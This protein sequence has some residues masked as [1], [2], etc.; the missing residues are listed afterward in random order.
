MND[1]VNELLEVDVIVG[2]ENYVN[3]SKIVGGLFGV[4][5]NGLIVL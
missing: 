1:L 2:F 4:E 3:L 5:T